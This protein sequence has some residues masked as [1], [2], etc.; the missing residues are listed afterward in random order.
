MR[1]TLAGGWRRP[2]VLSGEPTMSK[3]TTL[4]AHIGDR[5]HDPYQPGETREVDDDNMVKHLVDT[6]VLGEYDAK[7]ETAFKNKAEGKAEKT[8]AA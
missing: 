8:K 5:P 6:K 1:M 7:A 4:E 2:P 3:F